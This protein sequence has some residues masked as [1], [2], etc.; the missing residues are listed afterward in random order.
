MVIL[1]NF[2]TGNSAVCSASNKLDIDNYIEYSLQQ[3]LGSFEPP[4]STSRLNIK[5]NFDNK[6]TA[7]SLVDNIKGID[8]K[9]INLRAINAPEKR[10]EIISTLFRLQFTS[11]EIVGYMLPNILTLINEIEK[12][13]NIDVKDAQAVMVNKSFTY[14]PETVG[15]IVD[16]NALYAT[17]LRQ[18][19]NG[20][21]DIEIDVPVKKI[22]PRYTLSQIKNN[23]V[24]KASFTTDFS[25][26]GYERSCNIRLATAKFNG[27][28]LASGQRMSFNAVVGPR[29]V[30]N[31]YKTAK[32]ISDGKYTDGI[33]GGVCQVSSTVYN[34]CLLSGLKIV[35]VNQHSLLS[36]YVPA[37]LDA[38][39]NSQSSDLIIENN[40]EYP[41]YFSA[42]ANNGMLEIKVYGSPN[43]Y[44]LRARSVVLSKVNLG[45]TEIIDT[46][47]K[48]SEYVKYKDETYILEK[49][50]EQVSSKSYLQ[51]YKGNKLVKEELLRTN[52]YKGNPTIVVR[53]SQERPVYEPPCT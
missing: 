9:S 2:F 28:I 25:Y 33:G 11:Q 7:Y 41:I 23:T 1:A 44:T 34:A 47:N 52:T 37:S 14:T 8:D 35:K 12:A 20:K 31:G 15:R 27:L 13:V 51:Y 16:I 48:Y 39:V 53:G 21:S 10:S 22:Q 18:I 32:I 46:N 5:F 6:T 36:S 30:D 50:N 40:T 3:A 38:M 26:S 29:T 45:V 17:I 24:Y 19:S 43:E 49:G 4:R 42:S